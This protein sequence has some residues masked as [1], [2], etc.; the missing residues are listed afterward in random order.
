MFDA[1]N[2]ALADLLSV[3]HLAYMLLGIVVGLGVGI[4]PGLGGIAGMSLLMP[5]IYGMDTVSA[6]AMLIGMVAVIPTGDTF[7]SVLMGIPGSSASQATVLDGYPLAKKGQAARALSAAFS[8]SMLGGV[9]GAIMLT[10]FIVVAKPL[11]L[12]FSTAELFMFAVFGLSVVGVLAGASIVRGVVA[13][14]LGLMFGAIGAAPA[15]GESRFDLKLDYL[16]DGIPL[17]IVGLGLFAIPE[18]AELMRRQRAIA[19]GATLGSGWLQGVRDT[20]RHWFLVLRSSALGTFIGA[21]PGL[22]GGVVDWIAYGHVVQSSK[23]S[24]QFGKG[25]VRGVIAPES[26]NNALQGGALMPTLLFGIPGSGSM[27]VFLGGMVLLGLQPG[28]SMVTTELT[29]TYTIAWTLAIASVIGAFICF[30]LAKPIARITFIPFDKI[31]PVML[32]LI[33]FAAFQ[34][35]RDLTDLLVLFGVGILGIYLRRFGWPRPAF[36]IGFVLSGQVEA[37]LYQALQFFGWG[38]LQRPGVLII[39]ALAAVS[40]LLAVRNRVSEDGA[41]SKPA[42]GK[43]ATAPVVPTGGVTRAERAPQLLFALLMMV[44]FGY[45]VASSYPLSFLGSVFPL[46]TSLVMLFFSALLFWQLWSA[47]PGHAAH[48]DQEVG[49]VA[50]GTADGSSVWPSIGWFV[51]L[52]GMTALVGFILALAVFITAYLV[53]RT[54]FGWLKS[55]VYMALCVGFMVTLGHFLTLDFPA[56]A[57]QRVVELPWPLK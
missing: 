36:L 7:T 28:P 50:T 26:A 45:G 8:A 30:L 27:A 11:I 16:Q 37:Y 23:D 35:R 14:G 56:G 25:D 33:C 57:L 44:L 6:I 39:G 17:V 2:S 48:C 21:I 42:E 9:C 53:T 29:L 4:L 22:G 3:Q 10:G 24:S 19:S 54:A 40:L 34:A 52:F 43:A 18:L 55:L 46:Y 31:A 12:M 51:L 20:L 49:A 32:M 1:M 15:T 13:C 47:A 41:V 5:F 38:F